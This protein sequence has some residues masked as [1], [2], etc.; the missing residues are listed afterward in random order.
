[1]SAALDQF[2]K[3]QEDRRILFGG[4]VSHEAV[5][6]LRMCRFPI[7]TPR[8]PAS[9][10]VSFGTE[11]KHFFV[12]PTRTASTGF[13]VVVKLPDL[14][15]IDD[16]NSVPDLIAQLAHERQLLVRGGPGR[17]NYTGVYLGYMLSRGIFQYCLT[18]GG[19]EGGYVDATIEVQ[20]L[21]QAVDAPSGA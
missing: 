2:I 9:S 6:R 19:K 20:Q 16:G 10:A 17:Y 13:R 5:N 12:S 4:R 8:G 15:V 3:E 14:T 7:E 18:N 11:P 1:M 21:E